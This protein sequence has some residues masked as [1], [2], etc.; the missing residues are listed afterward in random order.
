MIDAGIL[1]R[2]KRSY[3][4]MTLV[5]P[6]ELAAESAKMASALDRLVKARTKDGE[7]AATGPGDGG[8][9]LFDSM[10][11][12]QTA[13]PQAP[14]GTHTNIVRMAR[15][16]GAAR[17]VR[18]QEAVALDIVAELFDHIFNDPTSPTA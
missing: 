5:D 15:D 13:Q 6:Q 8:L 11:M 4:E 12:L 7:G 10:K 9:E 2:L 3:R 14:D 16:S 17:D 1:P 18:P